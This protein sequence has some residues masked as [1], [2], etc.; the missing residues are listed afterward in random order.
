MFM[1]HYRLPTGRIYYLKEKFLNRVLRN[2]WRTIRKPAAF[3]WERNSNCTV[4]ATLKPTYNTAF[5]VDYQFL[6]N[7]AGVDAKTL[8]FGIG[9][10][11]N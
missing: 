5:K 6:N 7:G 10:Q 4:G 1:R 3:I 11:F 9:Y 2:C 8:N